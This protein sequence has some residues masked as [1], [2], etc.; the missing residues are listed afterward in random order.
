MMFLLTILGLALLF[1]GGE[2]L[3]RGAVGLALRFKLSPGL[4]ALTVVAWGTSAPELVVSLQASLQD[5]PDIALGNVIGSNIANIL[6]IL[7]SAALVRP[8]RCL[9]RVVYRDGMAMLAASLLLVGLAW[10]GLVS[11]WAGLGMLLILAGLLWASYRAERR[12][13][14]PSSALPPDERPAPNLPVPKA[15]TAAGLAGLGLLALA[16]GS[17]ALI[18]GAVALARAAGISEAVIGLSLVSVGT[19]LPEMATSLVAAWRRQ[20]DVAVGN[21]IGSNIFNIL[22][23][24]GISATA[25]P[26]TVNPAMAKV[27]VWVM[28]AAA[29]ALLPFLATGWRLNRIEGGVLLAGYGAY[30]AWLF[31]G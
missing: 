24:L 4:I 11:R 26:L 12:G 5:R 9:P 13:V 3:V 14:G 21:V 22:G 29:L 19:S 6:L 2:L 27:D 23:I 28:L 7:G 31:H 18:S 10:W 20:A 16:G 15:W 30:L 1:W 8:L 25:G 17:Q